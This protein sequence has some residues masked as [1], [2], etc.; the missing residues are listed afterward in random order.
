MRTENRIVAPRPP[1]REMRVAV[2]GA[3]GYLGMAVM[4]ELLSRGATAVSFG[5]GQCAGVPY[6]LGDRPDLTGYD[7]LVHLAW[8]HGS[9]SAEEY[10]LNVAGSVRLVDEARRAGAAVV[11]VSSISA[12][13]GRHSTYGHAKQVVER[14]V[15]T[16]GGRVVRPGLV[17]DAPLAG[18]PLLLRTAAEKLPILP[19]PMADDLCV[20][21]VSRMTAAVAIVD[22]AWQQDIHPAICVTGEPISLRDLAYR[23]QEGM[24]RRRRVVSVAPWISVGLFRLVGLSGKRGRAIQDSFSGLL[25]SQ[26]PGIEESIVTSGAT[27]STL[28]AG[29]S[30]LPNTLERLSA[31]DEVLR[32]KP[33]IVEVFQEIHHQLL[34][35]EAEH[36]R[37]SASTRVELG[38][39]SFPLSSTDPGVLASEVVSGASV[40]LVFD[41][42]RMPFADQSVSTL[43]L[44]NVFH[45]F[46]DRA[47]FLDEAIRVLPVGGLVVLFEPYHGLASQLMYP[48]LFSTETFDK[49]MLGWN[50]ESGGPTVV[51]NQALSYIVFVRDRSEFERHFKDLEIV[52]AQPF[53]NWPRYLA[54]GGLNFR[55]VL[56]RR[57]FR[58]LKAIEPR[59]GRLHQ[60]LGL[61]QFIVL[62]RTGLTR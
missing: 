53:T 49:K 54:S 39:G 10:Q 47:R 50:V 12:R 25:H 4:Q 17:V 18:L 37:C 57:A 41:G 55:R 11:F 19:L 29:P 14:A 16:A 56:P 48:R 42:T 38:S 3:T 52:S 8:S 61:H 35:L 7:V 9:R 21:V 6:Q 40:D 58:A 34:A 43:F 20:W 5:R 59:L 26:N 30:F 24:P 62:R 60:V 1:D 33:E 45:H 46:G 28:G 31:H 44:Q 13:A 27:E 51:A 36:S 15:E 22:A 32:S 23:V 2:T